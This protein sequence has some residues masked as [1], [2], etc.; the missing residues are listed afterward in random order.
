[1]S[2]V[3]SVG[4]FTF[5][6]LIRSKLLFVWVISVVIL[7]VLSFLLSILSFGSVLE[8]FMDLG[9]TGMEISGILVLL[10]SLI[11]TYNT[12]MDQ[13]AIFLHL[14][15][16]LT[17][18]EYLLGR[19]LGFF[20]VI[21]IIGGGMGLVVVG[22]VVGVGGGQVP[23]LFFQCVV[24][25]L[26][27]LFV[28]TVVGLTYQMIATSMVG[29]FLYVFSTI[30][31]GHCVGIVTWLLNQQLAHWLKI[32]LRVVFYL[33]PNMEIFNLKDRIYDPNLVLGAAQWEEVL[34]YAFAY[35]FVVFLVGW[36]NLE[37]REFK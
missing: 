34:L 37:K 10:L 18:G 2:R 11:V 13:K 17:R 31:L 29:M 16:P 24:F 19:I 30:F 32:L 14:A 25:I 33:L 3:F 21:S 7:C 4:L 6:E 1:M 8:I 35:S 22:L 28:L 9:L 36:V 5:R 23:P 26:L 20:G 27:E 12:E 15:K